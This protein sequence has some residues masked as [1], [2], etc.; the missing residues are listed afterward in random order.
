MLIY[1]DSIQ[2]GR[3]SDLD[4]L[5][6]KETNEVWVSQAT[7]GRMLEWGAANRVSEKLK[8]KSLKAFLAYAGV[9]DESHYVSA[10]D[11]KGRKNKVKV[12]PY[13]TFCA[14]AGWEIM[15]GAAPLSL[16]NE[17]DIPKYLALASKFV[18]EKGSVSS[19]KHQ[20]QPKVKQ[21]SPEKRVQ[22][23]LSK[24]ENGQTEVLTPVGRIDILTLLEIIEVKHVKSWKSA[25]GQIIAY[26]TYY[27]SH[28]KRIHLFGQCHTEMQ[29]TIRSICQKLN[30]IVTFE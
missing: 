18:N 23:R 6:D 27:P 13:D 5:V 20:W 15:R 9:S 19:S 16:S 4:V 17:G 28:Q 2:Y 3:F 7:I 12:I 30:V 10:K 1:F 26:G 21:E 11:S 29:Q 8:S 22:L 25:L 14:L 24:K